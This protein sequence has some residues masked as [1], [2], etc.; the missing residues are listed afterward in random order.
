MTD[1]WIYFLE[2]RSILFFR[3]MT[4]PNTSPKAIFFWIFKS[5]YNVW[6]VCAIIEIFLNMYVYIS[7][8]FLNVAL[9]NLGLLFYTKGKRDLVLYLEV[10]KVI[11]RTFINFFN[12]FSQ[13]FK[14]LK[15]KRG[16]F[17]FT[18][19]CFKSINILIQ[20]KIFFFILIK[21]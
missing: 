18:P 15:R 17:I 20:T 13:I 16:F 1:L 9:E 21:W 14:F 11:Q 4:K 10:P 7:F 5:L 2:C 6:K 3:T 8:S 19:M 12:R